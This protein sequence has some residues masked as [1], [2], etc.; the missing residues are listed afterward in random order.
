MRVAVRQKRL[1]EIVKYATGYVTVEELAETLQV[2]KRTI[3]SDLAALE[4]KGNRFEKKPGAGIKLRVSGEKPEA[5]VTDKF[6][7]EY[8]RLQLVHRLLFEEKI[9]T[10]QS[11]ADK[12]MVS[13]SSIIAD[14]HYVKRE[15]LN[16]ES[17]EL[18]G[19]EQGTRFAGKEEQWKRTMI[20]FNE[21]LE[22]EMKLSFRNEEYR[23]VLSE[24][25]GLDL[26]L[27]CYQVVTHLR[28]YHIYCA[29]EYYLANIFNVLLVLV[30]RMSKGRHHE[31]EHD[32]FY[33][34]QIMTLM[35]YVVSEELIG[36]VVKGTGIS[37]KSGDIYF[38]ALYLKANRINFKASDRQYGEH[39]ERCTNAMID[40]MSSCVNVDLRQDK[41]LYENLCLHLIPMLHRL[42][43]DI[44]IKNPML[45]EIKSEYNLM[46][47]L[48]WLVAD[49]FAN[50][51]GLKATED[52][53]GFLMLY[54][55]NALEK[56][57]KSKRILVVCPNGFVISALIA[58]KIRSTLPPL[59]IIEL[60][61]VEDI[62]RFDFS[63]I[64]FVVSTIPLEI[65]DVTVVVV[66]MLLNA[67]DL[68]KIEEAYKQKLELPR[69]R[70][71]VGRLSEIGNYLKPSHIF[72]HR[73]KITKEEVIHKVCEKL[74][75]DHMV[76][77]EFEVS[78]LEREKKG[79]TDNVYGGAIPHGALS[80]V[81]KT[82]LA[83]W[84]NHESVRWSK[85]KVKVIVFFA[86]AEED[87]KKSKMVLE[88]GFS[89]IKSREMVE[90]LGRCGS[91]EEVVI[92]I[93]GGDQGD[94]E[95][96]D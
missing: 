26:V 36:R 68:K 30:Y 15:I 87:I 46:F 20:A 23:E 11:M 62:E 59:D 50:E 39:F 57:K 13:V 18:I 4:K 61:S 49:A 83:V 22:T 73:G 74:Y 28:D 77:P 14:I 63:N 51:F 67:N 9:I 29:A 16:E 31:L 19:D 53:V 52:E 81:Q 82:C 85:Y 54:F 32:D 37:C 44:L 27:R 24:F 25:Y 79:A 70:E 66:S 3:H 6:S 12:Y 34:E 94:Q 56:Q 64:D 69:E 89:L 86:L 35:N 47:E 17:V 33:S 72:Y 90:R 42:K 38:F 10:Y 65:K 92:C 40:R 91:K 76:K 21:Y 55:Q 45:E 7:P 1:L 96:I 5:D 80:T 58:N 88:R 93:Y 2:S 48:T 43:Y 41:E 8:R 75:Q 95:R 60:A 78:V 84:V 71:P